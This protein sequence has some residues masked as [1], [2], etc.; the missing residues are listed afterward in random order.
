MVGLLLAR[1]D[2]RLVFGAWTVL[3][4]LALAILSIAIRHQAVRA[5]DPKAQ[6]L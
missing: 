2:W 3:P 4:L 1:G 5:I 6:P